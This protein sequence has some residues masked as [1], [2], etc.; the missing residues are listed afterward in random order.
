[1]LRPCQ[2]CNGDGFERVTCGC[3]EAA[4]PHAPTFMSDDEEPRAGIYHKFWVRRTDGSSAAGGKHQ[5]CD[6]FVLDWS[7][8]KYAC[9]AAL[10]YA[11]ACESEY[12]ELAAAL[13]RR[14]GGGEESKG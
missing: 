12:P 10:A 7:H 4:C 6:Y 1:V 8:D 2:H 14:A 5:R 13:R 3:R 9:T 11:D